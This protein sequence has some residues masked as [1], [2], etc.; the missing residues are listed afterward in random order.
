M[1]GSSSRKA[2][3]WTIQCFWDFFIKECERGGGLLASKGTGTAT[4]VLGCI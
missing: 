4:Y 2:D 3:V 1:H